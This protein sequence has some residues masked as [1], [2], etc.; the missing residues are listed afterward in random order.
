[1]KTAYAVPAVTLA[2]AIG[3]VA[4]AAAAPS[5]ESQGG[6]QAQYN[7]KELSIDKIQSPSDPA[8]GQ[9]ADIQSPRDPATGQATGAVQ[10]SSTKQMIQGQS[11]AY[12]QS[13]TARS[14]SPGSQDAQYKVTFEDVLVTSATA[15]AAG[16]TSETYREG[17]VNDATHRT[18]K[19]HRNR[20]G[21]R[22]KRMHKP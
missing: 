20:N 13:A 22:G 14:V 18:K 7:P 12:L 5:V 8:S 6:V 16:T 21:A 15:P 1:M 2:L 4:R 10:P 3:L 11:G 17:G 9:A 19:P